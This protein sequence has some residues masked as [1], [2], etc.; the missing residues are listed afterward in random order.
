MA[1]EESK[2]KNKYCVIIP[3]YQEE[4]RIA[5]VITGALEHCPDITVIDDGSADKTSEVARTA[6]ANVIRHERN[7]GKGVAL[8]TGFRH[9]RQHGFPVV[10]TMDADGQHDPKEIPRFIEAYERTRIPVLVGNRM[11]DQKKMPLV[12][13]WTNQTMSWLLSKL[14]KQ[15]VPDTQCGYRLYQTDL[16][17]FVAT[18]AERFA[19]ESEILLR[20]AER[21]IRI[22]S[23]RIDAIYNGGKSKITPIRDTWRFLKMLAAHSYK[24]S[25]R[26]KRPLEQ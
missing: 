2:E 14:M 1:I 12:R 23:V 4:K 15:Y 7:R 8:V 25:R 20:I 13:R 3:A 26:R 24:K 19:A 6:G 5:A 10:V 11:I 16:I 9:A 17:P 21:G 18:E 22:D